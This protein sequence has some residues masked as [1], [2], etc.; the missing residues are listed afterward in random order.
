[1]Q[2]QPVFSVQKQNPATSTELYIIGPMIRKM[3]EEKAKKNMPMASDEERSG[4]APGLRVGSG[5]WKWP[6][7]WPYGNDEFVRKDEIVDDKPSGNPLNGMMGLPP[8]AADEEE[9]EV[10]VLDIL[11]YWGSEKADIRT[12]IDVEA[13]LS[14]KKYVSMF[15]SYDFFYNLQIDSFLLCLLPYNSRQTDITVST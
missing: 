3:R 11:N 2:N 5:A 7:V 15:S 13:S 12:E 6:P 8:A 14:L 9:K 4:E 1:M 10:D